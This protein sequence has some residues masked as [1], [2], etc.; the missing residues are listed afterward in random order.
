MR[1]A[2][3]TSLIPSMRKGYRRA[4]CLM[5][6][7]FCRN[8]EG[9]AVAPNEESAITSESSVLAGQLQHPI[10]ELPDQLATLLEL[11]VFHPTV[12]EVCVKCF[13]YLEV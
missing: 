5:D 2:S 7:G 12:V 3:A 1:L 8:D 6:S 9:I 11:V 13:G 10:N 4:S